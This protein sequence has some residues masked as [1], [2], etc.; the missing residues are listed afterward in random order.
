[1]NE[2]MEKI[3]I[4]VQNLYTHTR[5]RVKLGSM[6]KRSVFI[7]A[8]EKNLY[9]FP[10]WWILNVHKSILNVRKNRLTAFNC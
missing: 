3:G 5:T 8:V 2:W 9:L 7:F 10:D 6:H 1:M 4:W